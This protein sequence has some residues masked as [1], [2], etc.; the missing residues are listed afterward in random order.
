MAIDDSFVLTHASGLHAVARK[1]DGMHKVAIRSAQD[2]GEDEQLVRL[3][4]FNLIA[5]C[6]SV[7]DADV[8]THT[9]GLIAQTHPCR[10]IVVCADPQPDDSIEADLSFQ[11]ALSGAGVVNAEYVRLNVSGEP[12]YHL[13]SVVTPLLVPDIP[14]YLWLVGAPPLVQAFGHDAIAICERLVIDTGEYPHARR[15]L[16]TMSTEL[17][18]AGDEIGLADLAW[19]RTQSWREVLAH[20]FEGSQT[21]EL[22]HHITRVEVES[23][24][25]K[26]STAG[27]LCAGWLSD[28]L[29]WGAGGPEVVVAAAEV[30]GVPEHELTAVRVTAAS[31]EHRA[32]ITL[33]R[34]EQ[35]LYSTIDID[36]GHT[37][38]Q[39]MTLP[40]PDVAQLVGGLLEQ[41]SDDPIYLRALHCAAGMVGE[42]ASA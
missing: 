17:R 31:T 6:I 8:A 25:G 11:R 37:T 12:A 4:A 19:A 36:G 34:R 5:I 32:T 7:D 27:W 14:V 28:R 9:A 39:A 42:K 23:C 29:N 24:G 1:L 35:T 18:N 33:E 13:S 40:A 30:D 21:R 3:L 2:Q 41:G 22:L 38:A 20:A 10:A 26:P 15:T 16:R